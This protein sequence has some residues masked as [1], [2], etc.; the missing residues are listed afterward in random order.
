ME[1]SGD[2]TAH[3]PKNPAYHAAYILIQA[4][5]SPVPF[6]GPLLKNRMLASLQQHVQMFTLWFG[7]GVCMYKCCLCLKS[8]LYLL[9]YM[10]L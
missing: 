1:W 6:E 9:K 8:K 5:F 10:S 7:E 3:H 2:I 4:F